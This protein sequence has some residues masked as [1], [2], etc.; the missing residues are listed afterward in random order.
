MYAATDAYV[1]PVLARFKLHLKIN[2]KE[3][4]VIKNYESTTYKG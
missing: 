2:V 1:S 3:L 4:D